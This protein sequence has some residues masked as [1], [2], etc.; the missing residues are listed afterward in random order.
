MQ[1]DS[2]SE[3]AEV[4]H[5]DLLSSTSEKDNIAGKDTKNHAHHDP[6]WTG[7]DVDFSHVDEKKVLRKLDLRLMP[8]LTLLYL[9]SF[10]DRGTLFHA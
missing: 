10:L 2:L 5:D 7:D 9:L 1:K 8:M 6:N 4:L 3:K